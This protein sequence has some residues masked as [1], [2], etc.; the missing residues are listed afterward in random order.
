MKLPCK[1]NRGKQDQFLQ[2]QK[3]LDKRADF[4]ALMLRAA[5]SYVASGSFL[6]LRNRI[7]THLVRPAQTG[8]GNQLLPRSPAAE[9]EG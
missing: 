1:N 2:V 7:E 9:G 3:Q 6:F 8:K 5:S 4:F